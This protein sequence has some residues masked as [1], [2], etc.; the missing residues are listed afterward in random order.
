[1]HLI[2]QYRSTGKV[3][4]IG[5]ATGYFLEVAEEE[6]FEPFGVE[7]SAYAAEIAQNKFGVNNI[8]NGTL[9]QCNFPERYLM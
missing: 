4:D 9:E 6:G 3:L 1:M 7:Y 8:F 2:K 5:C